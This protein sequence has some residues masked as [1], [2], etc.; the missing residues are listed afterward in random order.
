MD[1]AEEERTDDVAAITQVGLRDGPLPPACVHGTNV[2]CACVPAPWSVSSTW[3]ENPASFPARRAARRGCT[4]PLLRASVRVF[5]LS[6]LPS[7]LRLVYSFAILFLLSSSSYAS[8]LAVLH[9]SGED[10]PRVALHES[11]VDKE[12]V[13]LALRQHYPAGYRYLGCLVIFVSRPSYGPTSRPR[14]AT[15]ID[16]V[17]RDGPFLGD[18]PVDAFVSDRRVARVDAGLL[19][20]RVSAAKGDASPLLAPSFLRLYSE[21]P[22]PGPSFFFF[23]FSAPFV[24]SSTLAARSPTHARTAHTRTHARAREHTH[25]YA[26]TAANRARARERSVLPVPLAPILPLSLSRTLCP[27]SPP[28]LLYHHSLAFSFNPPSLL[29]SPSSLPRSDAAGTKGRSLVNARPRPSCGSRSSKRVLPPS[30][31]F[32]VI[33]T[34]SLGVLLLP[35]RCV[36]G[37]PRR[38]LCPRYRLSWCRVEPTRS[39]LHRHAPVFRAADSA[40]TSHGAPRFTPSIPHSRSAT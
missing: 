18:R 8:S 35:R 23:F 11:V 9:R 7:F 22:P 39:L 6:F 5:S 16:R 2:V 33:F 37:V 25:A 14:A 24:L 10:P 32:A 28:P 29:S 34:F 3:R 26:R 40:A 1:D 12:S 38:R 31:A 17:A 15:K 19:S 36:F 30:F 13:K 4:R 20:L 21:G 27:P